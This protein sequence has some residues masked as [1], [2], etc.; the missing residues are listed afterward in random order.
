MNTKQ[1]SADVP[2]V[3]A[4][5]YGVA[6]SLDAFLLNGIQFG[7]LQPTVGNGFL[8]KTAS[9]LLRDLASLEEQGRHAPATSPPR[10]GEVLAA[11]RATCQQVIELITGLS[12]FRTFPLQQLR[13]TVSQIPVLRGE[14]VQRIRELEACFQTPQPFYQSRPSS[15]SAAVNDFLA[16]LQ[17]LFAKQW[18]AANAAR[19]ENGAPTLS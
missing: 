11:L 4:A 8:Q 7:V 6:L 15:S 10:V 3:Q 9:N 16:N 13:A 14:C 1:S 2:E 18:A 12:S 17:Q 19:G 5:I